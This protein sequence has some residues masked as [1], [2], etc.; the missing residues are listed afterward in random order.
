M[1]SVF[2]RHGRIHSQANYA[3]AAFSR[4]TGETL[5]Y[6]NT[7]SPVSARPSRSELGAVTQGEIGP[8]KEGARGHKDGTASSWHGIIQCSLKR[9]HVIVDTIAHRTKIRNTVDWW[10]GREPSLDAGAPKRF[11]AWRQVTECRQ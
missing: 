8:E 3:A 6:R 5:G 11:C 10:R 9:R 1:R 4:I 7:K 2:R